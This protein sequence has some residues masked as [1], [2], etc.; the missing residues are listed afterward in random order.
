MRRVV[1][2]RLRLHALSLIVLHVSNMRLLGLIL[3][4]SSVDLGSKLS[5][6]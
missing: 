6:S 1:H 2:L 4:L 3:F 5:D